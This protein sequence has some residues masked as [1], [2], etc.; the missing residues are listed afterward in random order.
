MERTLEYLYN[1]S[2]ALVNGR[3]P[4]FRPDSSKQTVTASDVVS[5]YQ[6]DVR[7]TFFRSSDPASFLERWVYV[8]L[9]YPKSAM[10]EGVQGRV[11][12]D[13]VI[14]EKGKVGDVKV[15]RG[16][17][18]RLDAEAVRVISAS[19]DWKPGVLRGKKVK[20]ALSVAVEFRLEKKKKK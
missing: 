16:A 5:F 12:V 9:K 17:D 4:E 3:S 19:P 10:E 11:T 15:V 7:P 20:T 13:F 18:P 2:V 1:F 6:C 8:Y 14:D